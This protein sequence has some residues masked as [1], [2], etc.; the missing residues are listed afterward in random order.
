ML[1]IT[2]KLTPKK[3]WFYTLAL[4]GLAAIPRLCCLDLVEFKRDEA[5]HYRMAY[6][7][8]RGHW[9]WTGSTAS[10]GLPSRR[11]SST[12]CPCR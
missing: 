9:R 10:I 1:H 11:S 4:I 5:N 3:E 2:R 12:P 6:F 7:L 8:T